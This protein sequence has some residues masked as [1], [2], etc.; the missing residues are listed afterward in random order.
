MRIGQLLCITG[1][2]FEKGYIEKYGFKPYTDINA[3][4]FIS[5]FGRNIYKNL[6]L[7]ER[8]KSFTVL[9][10]AGGDILWFKEHRKELDRIK[11]LSNIKHIAISTCL[12]KDLEELNIPY[13]FIPITPYKNDDIHPEPLGDSIYLYKAS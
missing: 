4:L 6:S 13:H 12:A 2:H 9:R 7:I 8:H 5:G 3:P 1:V 11:I 10:W